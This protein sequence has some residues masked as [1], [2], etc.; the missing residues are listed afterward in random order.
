MATIN[1]KVLS[2]LTVLLLV[3]LGLQ[4]GALKIMINLAGDSN[5]AAALAAAKIARHPAPSSE[6]Q[7]ASEAAPASEAKAVPPVPESPPIVEA[8][9]KPTAPKN[10]PS[11]EAPKL[12]VAPP[13]AVAHPSTDAALI[14]AEAKLQSIAPT[15]ANQNP[16][17]RN[18]PSSPEQPAKPT[19]TVPAEVAVTTATSAS[20]EVPAEGALQEP[21]WLKNRNP[22]HYTVQLY[23]GKDMGTLKEI[24][25]STTSTEPQ[26]YYATGTRS[27]TWYSL[28]AGDYPDSA[29]AQAAADKLTTRSPALKPWIR[30]FDEI[31]AK[32]R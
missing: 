9:P 1:W 7:I 10:E 26:A 21:V 16:S 4:A 13:P 32:L 8:A 28:V 24:A 20:P 18:P 12:P 25:A 27:G 19:T 22:K 3:A 11:P 23:S 30:R 29:A 5:A 31:Q 15:N 6:R 14:A 17:H 2:L